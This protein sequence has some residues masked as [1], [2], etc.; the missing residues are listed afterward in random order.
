MSSTSTALKPF[1]YDAPDPLQGIDCSQALSEDKAADGKSLI[2]PQRS[3]DDK[4]SPWYEGC[5]TT[6]TDK[7]N[8]FDFHIYYNMN[9]KGQVEH[10]KRLHER[11]RREFPELRIYK[12]WENAVGPHPTAMFEV[13][14]FTPAQTGALMSFLVAYRAGLSVLIHPNTDD[15]LRDHTDRATWMGE[16]YPLITEMLRAR[17]RF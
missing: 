16:R 6:F 7:N 14:T 13:N 12:F 2:N 5:P 17:P 3:N 10:A 1:E 9:S 8:I 11:I 15:E 4:L